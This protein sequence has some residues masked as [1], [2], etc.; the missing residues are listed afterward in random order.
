MLSLQAQAGG[1]QEEARPAHK[2]KASRS[3]LPRTSHEGYFAVHSD[4]PSNQGASSPKARVSQPL[5]SSRD[6]H[7]PYVTVWRAHMMVMTII[8]ILAVDFRV[9]PRTFGKCESWGTS[10]VSL[11]FHSLEHC[12]HDFF[13]K[14]DLGVGSFV[15]SLGV[16]SAIPIL[17][18][19]GQK[20]AS[21]SIWTVFSRTRV[22]LALGLLRLLSVKGTDYPVSTHRNSAIEPAQ[23]V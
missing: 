20:T 18:R 17:Q 11:E 9:F 22:V 21:A 5:L 1:V 16:T 13:T 4:R 14:M 12:A 8:S 15:F 2:R 23:S 10:L 6:L 3:P 19:H 7:R